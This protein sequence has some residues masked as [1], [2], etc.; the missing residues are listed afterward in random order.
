M[1]PLSGVASAFGIVSLALQLAQSAFDFKRFRDAIHN[2]PAEV[3]RLKGVLLRLHLVAEAVKTLLE[4]QETLLGRHSDTSTTLYLALN[5]CLK[6]WLQLRLACKREQVEDFERQLEQA[7]SFLNSSLLLNLIQANLIANSKIL[8]L[9]RLLLPSQQFRTP[10]WPHSCNPDDPLSNANSHFLVPI[11]PQPPGLPVGAIKQKIQS[12]LLQVRVCNSC[13]L[14]VRLPIPIFSGLLSVPF[15]LSI[16]K[17]IPADSA[18]IN[19]CRNGDGEQVKNLLKS[20]TVR[21]NDMTPSN[22]T[23]LG[24]GCEEVV[25]LLLREGA[26]PNIPYGKGQTSPLQVAVRF[27]SPSIVRMLIQRGADPTYVSG[28]RWSLFHYMF[29]RSKSTLTKEYFSILWHSVMFDEV[30]DSEGWTALHRCAAFG[31]ADD[32]YSLHQL[33]A[34]TWPARYITRWGQTLVHIAAVMNNLS[35]L[36]AL[37]NV[38]MKLET[39][40][41]PSI[42]RYDDIDLVDFSGW[43]PLHLAVYRCA[44]DTMKWLL[45]NGADPHR[46]TYRTAEWF[47]ADREGEA[48]SVTDLATMSE[49]PCLGTFYTALIE[50][51]YNVT[52]QANDLYWFL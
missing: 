52:I 28:G 38:Q 37:V 48:F 2:S 24:A 26:D 47:P 19:A 20:K 12:I 25:Q 22:D 9:T 43:T 16:Q 21:P 40:R 31:T 10:Q 46:M 5:T 7:I 50:I 51:C 1:D 39:S 18:I 13:M 41:Q 32:V 27:G 45:Q 6:N 35:T 44:K 42:H 8:P 4:Q 30:R 11:P 15:S 36:E 14:L 33:G 17:V 23:P 49:E 3:D 29:D 34:S